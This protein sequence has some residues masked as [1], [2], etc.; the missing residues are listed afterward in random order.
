MYTW[1][2]GIDELCKNSKYLICGFLIELTLHK[3]PPSSRFLRYA[4]LMPHNMFSRSEKYI[5]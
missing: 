2:M 4:A 1:Q 5:A 3:D